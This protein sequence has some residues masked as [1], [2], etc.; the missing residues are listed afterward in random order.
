MGRVAAEGVLQKKIAVVKEHGKVIETDEKRRSY[1]LTYHP[2]AVL[3]FPSKFKASMEEAKELKNSLVSTIVVG[4][5][6]RFS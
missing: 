4:V 1:F 6:N 2:A 3:R 5:D